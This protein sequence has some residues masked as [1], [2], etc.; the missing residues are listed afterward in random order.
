MFNSKALAGFG[1]CCL[2][3]APLFPQHAPGF[4]V[5]G[6]VSGFA[7][8]VVGEK[9]RSVSKRQSEINVRDRT[10]KNEEYKVSELIKRYQESLNGIQAQKK[11]LDAL[12]LIVQ[13]RSVECDQIEGMIPQLEEREKAIAKAREELA[14]A[15][16]EQRERHRYLSGLSKELDGIEKSQQQTKEKYLLWERDL[17]YQKLE[18][19]R[20]QLELKQAQNSFD[21]T[22]QQYQQAILAQLKPQ[23]EEYAQKIITERQKALDEWAA[24]IKADKEE[25]DRI[26]PDLQ[27]KLDEEVKRIN[28][29]ANE[30]I[31]EIA[32]DCNERIKLALE[33]RNKAHD[34][35]KQH[36]MVMAG[37]QIEENQRLKKVVYSPGRHWYED[38]AD[39]VIEFLNL[40]EIPVDYYQALPTPDEKGFYVELEPKF[41]KEALPE[42]Y[43]K[44]S[45]DGI[46]QAL[47]G[48]ITDCKH[49]PSIECANK[50]I[51]LTFVMN[52]PDYVGELEKASG[53]AARSQQRDQ[54]KEF[55]EKTSQV[56]LLGT[57]GG[58]KTELLKNI[59]GAFTQ[60][61][62]NKP[63]LIITNGKASRSSRELGVAK[64][65]SV[66][67][68]I[69]GLLEAAVEITYR[70]KLN[71]L[72]EKEN[73]DDPPYPDHEPIIYLFD[74]YSEIATKWNSVTKKRMEAVIEEFRFNLDRKRQE[75]L[76]SLL[77]DISPKKFAPTLLN[78][79][80][81]LGRSEK[82]RAIVA[83]QNLQPAVLGMFK[84]DL[85]NPAFICVGDLVW[86]G[87]ANRAHKFQQKELDE[88]FKKRIEDAEDDESKQYFALFCVPKSRAHFANLPP[89]GKYQYSHQHAVQNQLEELY[90]KSADSPHADGEIGSEELEPLQDNDDQLVNEEDKNRKSGITPM[91]GTGG[92]LSEDDGRRLE[93]IQQLWG[94]EKTTLKEIISEVWA[95]VPGV[96][97]YS[98][99]AWKKAREEYRRLTG[100]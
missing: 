15:E 79:V 48:I 16:A 67:T 95:D 60:L 29:T 33:D 92:L 100:K 97:K 47:K 6:A 88:E 56:A 11:E 81:R 91:L 1:V 82:V 17:E 35:W 27:Q 5:S 8:T 59:V 2:L 7:C 96:D 64:Y 74:E 34:V 70:I 80:W 50:R 26:L 49:K 14:D 41:G 13:Q 22:L 89:M 87:I 20:Q 32:E 93:H 28:E 12:A 4:L 76:D 62:G 36:Y 39:K 44:I 31:K 58:G 52:S 90:R 3:S 53:Q 21:D 25:I 73:P 40:N 45:N 18:L 69:F 54:F 68:A 57:T 19:E 65:N 94:Q 55:L 83:G 10:L 37:K 86:W 99:R 42:V 63:Q 84:M 51:K 38:K 66:E 9:E 75:I 61:M 78:T 46:K 71:E 98:S 43:T 30:K 23:A 77:E 24:Q 85:W 72:A